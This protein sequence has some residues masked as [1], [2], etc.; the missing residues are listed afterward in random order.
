LTVTNKVDVR[1]T[2]EHG[3]TP[4]GDAETSTEVYSGTVTMQPADITIYMGGK[5]GYTGVVDDTGDIV[6]N[7]DGSE[8]LPEPGFYFTLPDEINQAFSNALGIKLEEA[9]DL[10]KYITVTATATDN[11]PRT[12]TLESYGNSES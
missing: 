2:T 12:W 4:V 5:G 9:V 3:S 6:Q 10:S 7:G 1:A 8:S 11:V